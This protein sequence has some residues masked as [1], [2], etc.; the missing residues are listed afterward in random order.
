MIVELA[1]AAAR[2]VG[3]CRILSGDTQKFRSGF[4]GKSKHFRH[5]LREFS[6]VGTIPWFVESIGVE[7]F[8]FTQF[9]QDENSPTMPGLAVAA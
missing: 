9:G 4:T 5:A 1:N 6:V 8:L 7:Q 3:P 2:L